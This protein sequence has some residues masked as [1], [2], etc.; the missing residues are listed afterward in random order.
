MLSELFNAVS[1]VLRRPSMRVVT[2]TISGAHTL[3]YRVT[4]GRAQNGKYPTMLLTVTGRSTGKAR[5]VP[6]I[7]VRDGE[8][9]V[10]AAAYSGSDTDPS[11][12]RNLQ[13]DPRAEVQVRGET[14]HVSAAEADPGERP[15]LWERLVQM[16]PYFTVYQ[17]RTER[18]IPVVVLTPDPSRGSPSG[19]MAH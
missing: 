2:K 11:W 17:R 5:T 18:A 19:G 6:V 10:I 16:Y 3:A 8:R 9:F 12:W 4:G 7:Y 1:A 14:I 15:R 13:A